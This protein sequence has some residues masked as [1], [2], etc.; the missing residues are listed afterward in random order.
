VAA[1]L[2]RGAARQPKFYAVLVLC[3]VVAVLL[4]FAGVNPIRALVRSQVLNGLVAVPFVFLVLRIANDRAVM[5]DKANGRLA[6]ALGWG[7]FVVMAAVGAAAG[8]G[9]AQ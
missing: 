8:W 6:N 1:R 7:P 2:R 5:G 4:N 9:L 3:S